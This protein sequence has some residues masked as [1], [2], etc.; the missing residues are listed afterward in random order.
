MEREEQE[1]EAHS[2][3]PKG[4]INQSCQEKHRG[5]SKYNTKGNIDLDRGAIFVNLKHMHTQPVII[6]YAKIQK[7]HTRAYVK[8]M[9]TSARKG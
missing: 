2:W 1:T 3:K 9:G 5:S 7:Y 4:T 6:H 8:H